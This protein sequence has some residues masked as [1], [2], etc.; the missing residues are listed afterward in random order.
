MATKTVAV[1]ASG[2]IF[3]FDDPEN[4]GTD[5][6]VEEFVSCG[7]IGTTG[8]TVD[9]TRL[10]SPDLTMEYI[11]GMKDPA[12]FEL[13]FHQAPDG[14]PKA[15]N[16]VL[17]KAAADA[18]ETIEVKINIPSLSEF[19]QDFEFSLALAGHRIVAPVAN[20]SVDF[21]VTGKITGV[22]LESAAPD[23]AP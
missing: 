17:L 12:D 15:A 11:G 7:D 3:T 21:M 16:Q 1:L 5:L 10:D 2:T 14:D 18:S 20:E 6:E 23:P 13:R 8:S 22:V 9:V 19:G 4:P